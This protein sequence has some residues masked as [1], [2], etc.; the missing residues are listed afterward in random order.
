MVD[1]VGAG[2]T[3]G[4]VLVEGLVKNGE[5]A[6]ENLKLV[7]KRAAKAAAITCTRAGA[8]PPTLAELESRS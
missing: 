2:D 4:A 8:K 7:L 1:T 5:L 3:V 6:G